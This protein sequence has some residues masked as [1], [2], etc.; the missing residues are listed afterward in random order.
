[1]MIM[2]SCTSKEGINMK[3]SCQKFSC[4]KL[5]R[6]CNACKNG[7]ALCM[8][9]CDDCKNKKTCNMSKDLNKK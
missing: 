7:A 2:S 5:G 3:R 1:M 8:P 4:L 6:T 9:T